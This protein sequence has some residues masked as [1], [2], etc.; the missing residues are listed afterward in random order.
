MSKTKYPR[1]LAIE[2]AKSIQPYLEPVTQPNRLMCCGSLRRGKPEVSDLELLFV[3]RTETV[4]DGLF[5]TKVVD[6]TDRV[7][8]KLLADG[9]IAK[10]PNVNGHFSFG[11][12]NKLCLH[13]ATGF[14]VDFFS[15]L[16]RNWFVA[17]VI[18]TG[19][20]ELNIRL[21]EAAAKRK[22]NLHAYG[23]GF[24]DREGNE[25]PVNSERELFERCGLPYMEPQDRRA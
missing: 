16:D 9:I 11:P 10:R 12:R 23:S 15:V 24:T 7:F 2:V 17:M 4:P 3:P 19:P 25:I 22:L 8:D 20:K 21:C 13:V 5:D 1:Q 14:P 18:R 6:M